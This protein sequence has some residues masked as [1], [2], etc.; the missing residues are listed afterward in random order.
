VVP[1]SWRTTGAEANR[2]RCTNTDPGGEPEDGGGGVGEDRPLGRWIVWQNDIV[3]KPDGY[4]PDDPVTGEA[5]NSKYLQFIPADTIQ[6]GLDGHSS[7]PANTR[8]ASR[9]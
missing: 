6:R 9:H 7:D 8:S 3:P 2:P 5:V 4:C 1:S